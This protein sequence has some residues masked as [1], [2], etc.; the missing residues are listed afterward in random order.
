MRDIARRPV[1]AHK[2]NHSPVRAAQNNSGD[3]D[4]V[5]RFVVY[6]NGT[7]TP[8]GYTDE[9]DTALFCRRRFCGLHAF[10]RLRRR[11]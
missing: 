6:N 4:A 1:L 8:E 7:L 5:A 2:I 11:R 9:T 10:A 3:D